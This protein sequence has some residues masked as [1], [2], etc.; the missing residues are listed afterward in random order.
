MICGSIAC[1]RRVPVVFR[2]TINDED[3]GSHG[4]IEILENEE[5]VDAVVRFVGKSKR[6]LDGLALRN[7]MLRQACGIERVRCTRDVAVVYE[8]RINTEDG[9][10]I[11]TLVVY[12]NEEPAD[13]VYGWSR[14]NGVPFRSMEGVLNDVC[15]SGV[16]IC[17]R[18]EP[19]DSNIS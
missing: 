2:R 18:R 9:S 15:E 19:V 1:S 16:A 6:S 13:K 4:E 12:K 5:V 7:A 17:T 11:G 10:L 3:G 8:Q 14:E